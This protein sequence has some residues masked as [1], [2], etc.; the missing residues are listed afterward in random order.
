[1][2]ANLDAYGVCYADVVKTFSEFDNA[3]IIRGTVPDTLSQVPSEK[4]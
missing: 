4:V 2:Q 1:M 3:V